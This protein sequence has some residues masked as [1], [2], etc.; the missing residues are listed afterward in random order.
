MA[1]VIMGVAWPGWYLW[2]G[3]IFFLGRTYAQP[4]D[5]I[6]PLDRRRKVLAIVGLIIFLLI[7]I[8]VPMRS[9]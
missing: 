1:L 4:L 6:T 9:L 8:P 2:A 7:F 5:D 3:M